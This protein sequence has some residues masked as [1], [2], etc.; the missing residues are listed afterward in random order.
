MK[1]NSSYWIDQRDIPD[2]KFGKNKIPNCE[3]T[4]FFTCRACLDYAVERN[5]SDKNLISE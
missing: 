2:S 4:N 1:N 5:I 3:C